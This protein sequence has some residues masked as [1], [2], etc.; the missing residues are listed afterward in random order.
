MLPYYV[1]AAIVIAI[2]QFTK[3]LVNQKIALGAEYPILWDFFLLTHYRNTGAAFGILKE[4]RWFFLVITAVVVLAIAWYLTKAVRERRKLIP[5]A[6]GLLLGG[7]LGNFYDRA[8][9]GEVVDFLQFNFG[10]YTFPI[11][12]LADT[13]ICIGV[14]LILLDSIL[15]W[16]EEK[17]SAAAH[18]ESAA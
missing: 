2:D 6:L 7:A 15:Q 14:G 8:V 9:H 3:Y 5:T 12:N 16:R 1:L 13:A 18:D 4:M 11:F 17:R 10:S